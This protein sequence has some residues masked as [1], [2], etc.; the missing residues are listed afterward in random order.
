MMSK[1]TPASL[2][3]TTTAAEQ[4]SMFA[5]AA[6]KDEFKEVL[7]NLVIDPDYVL[8]TQEEKDAQ[9][10]A[11]IDLIL[12]NPKAFRKKMESL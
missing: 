5:G 8:P 4:G 6:L 7:A 11:D 1:P 2:P 10:A 12:N 9:F 3:C